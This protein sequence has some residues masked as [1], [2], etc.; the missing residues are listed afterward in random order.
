MQWK[1]QAGPNRWSTHGHL[2]SC[3]CS[4]ACCYVSLSVCTRFSS[5]HHN[6]HEVKDFSTEDFKTGL[7][8][9]TMNHVVLC[10]HFSYKRGHIFTLRGHLRHHW[11]ASPKHQ[12]HLFI[13]LLVHLTYWLVQHF[14]WIIARVLLD[15][16]SVVLFLSSM[17]NT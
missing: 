12:F 6:E 17:C 5:A 3:L 8:V 1:L 14:P 11:F 4:Q 16:C 9:W 7:N 10:G 2:I 15:C 13:W